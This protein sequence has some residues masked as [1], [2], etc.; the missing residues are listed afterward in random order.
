MN[1]NLRYVIKPLLDYIDLNKIAD[2]DEIC[3]RILNGE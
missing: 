3:D 2:P 1:L